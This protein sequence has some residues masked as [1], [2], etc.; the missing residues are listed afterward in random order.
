MKFNFVCIILLLGLIFVN[1]CFP[2]LTT[3]Q[4]Q[5]KK[6]EIPEELNL[7]ICEAAKTSKIEVT[8]LS[9]QK[10]KHYNQPSNILKETVEEGNVTYY[11][12]AEKVFILIEVN[13]K[14][15]GNDRLF[16]SSSKFSVKD[17]ELNIYYP[18]N[19]DDYDSLKFNNELS[20]NQIIK[21]KILFTV[22]NNSKDL[23]LCLT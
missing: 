5:D 1:G 20:Q 16:V 19:F 8:V 12:P 2:Q 17:S 23:K 15:V 9:A 7:T 10:T 6:S 13:I 18:K 14:N 4:K 22:P 11:A 3:S 21:R